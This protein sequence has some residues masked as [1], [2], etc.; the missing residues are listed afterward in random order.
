MDVSR[1]WYAPADITR[2]IDALAYNK[3]NRLHLHITDAQFLLSLFVVQ[4][5]AVWPIPSNITTGED[6]LF[7]DR[8]VKFILNSA[9][10]VAY[11]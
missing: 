6:V 1:V 10:Q 11:P 8:R 3:F 5:L 7:V 4:I 2:M 9:V